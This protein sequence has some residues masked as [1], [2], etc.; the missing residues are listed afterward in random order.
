MSRYARGEIGRLPL[1]LQVP[2]AI[3]HV[4]NMAIA[5]PEAMEVH[6]ATVAVMTV[7]IVIIDI[8]LGDTIDW[9]SLSGSRIGFWDG[10]LQSL[11][12]LYSSCC[13]VPRYPPPGEGGVDFLGATEVP[14]PI[15]L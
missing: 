14:V 5:V 7:L 3:G 8:A 4:R 15:P 10:S 6:A 2:S 9:F 13:P 12:V 11:T 1:T